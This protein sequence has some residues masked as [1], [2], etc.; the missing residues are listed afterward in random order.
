MPEPACPVRHDYLAPLSTL[1]PFGSYEDKPDFL[2][3]HLAWLL[4]V[5]SAFNADFMNIDYKHELFQSRIIDDRHTGAL[6]FKHLSIFLEDLLMH[7][8]QDFY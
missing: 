4:N 3:D 1:S 6:V 7:Y 2:S 5:H 8:F